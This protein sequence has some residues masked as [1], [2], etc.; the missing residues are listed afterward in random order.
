MR[1]WAQVLR[2]H[3][4]FLIPSLP[5]LLILNFLD[6]YF[7]SSNTPL[8]PFTFFFFTHSQIVNYGEGKKKEVAVQK[9][10]GGRFSVSWAV[11]CLHTLASLLTPHFCQ[12]YRTFFNCSLCTHS[13]VLL[14]PICFYH[15]SSFICLTLYKFVVMPLSVSSFLW[16]YILFPHPNTHLFY[17]F[18]GISRGEGG[19]IHAYWFS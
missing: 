7:V 13:R 2:L 18:K 9:G 3:H 6:S 14:F 12:W 16:V 15:E 4:V 10:R 19:E 8:F 1:R 11:N 5:S 17:L